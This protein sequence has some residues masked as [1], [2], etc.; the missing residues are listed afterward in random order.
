MIIIRNSG[1]CLDCEDSIESKHRHDYVTC[2]CG[3]CS[4]DGGDAYLRRACKEGARFVDTS[5]TLDRV[6]DEDD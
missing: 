4:V 2:S 3:N 1:M 5:I 6:D